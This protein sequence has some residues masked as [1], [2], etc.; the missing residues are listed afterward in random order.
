MN[1]LPESGE[2]DDAAAGLRRINYVQHIIYNR[3]PLAPT[4]SILANNS[5]SR[6][7]KLY[8]GGASTCGASAAWTYNNTRP[9]NT[10]IHG[11]IYTLEHRSE[12]AHKNITDV[13]M[14]TKQKRKRK[15]KKARACP[16]MRVHTY[17]KNT[18]VCVA[19]RTYE[20]EVGQHRCWSQPLQGALPVPT[21]ECAFV[22]R[23]TELPGPR[24]EPELPM[25]ILSLCLCISNVVSYPQCLF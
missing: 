21:P 12:Q 22:L 6:A 11:W 24:R 17:I 14:Q 5:C 15:K 4:F 19:P 13:K 23:P 2:D 1:A 16:Y 20:G 3:D 18:R 25:P 8:A 7:S 9:S 10:H